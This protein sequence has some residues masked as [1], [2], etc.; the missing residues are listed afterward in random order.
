MGI[1]SDQQYD[2][3]IGSMYDA[4]LDAQRWI[5]VVH[6][7]TRVFDAVGASVYTPFAIKIGL[8]PLWATNADPEYVAAY[9]SKY[10]A[11]DLLAEALWRRV[12]ASTIVYSLD[13]M[14]PRRHDWPVYNELLVPR[15]VH[16]AVGLMVRADD[17]RAGQ[18]SVYSPR[19]SAERLTEAKGVMARLAGHF[20]RAI[21]LHWHLASARQAADATQ[22]TLDMFV[23]GVMWL[24][25]DAT[26]LYTN[27]EMDR[28]LTMADGIALRAGRLVLPD[29]RDQDK[30]LAAIRAAQDGV[31]TALL[32]S[33]PSEQEPYRLTISAL[34]MSASALRLPNASAI[35]FV[36]EAPVLAE[37]SVAAMADA[38]HLTPAE[39]RVLQ[40]LVAGRNI[41][42]AAEE[43]GSRAATVRTQTKSILMKC[44][45]SR[46]ADLI[47]LVTAF[48]QV[49][50]PV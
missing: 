35:A 15:G 19:W 31:Q 9:A 47:R 10:A 21:R 48:P 6:Q 39:T 42:A 28:I 26:V 1:L 11:Q 8:E 45:V 38:Y 5:E 46:Q 36:S 23:T 7:V 12:P 2:Q 4:A 22:I 29:R 41:Q 20:S 17:H 14:L 34:P 43:I 24:S 30:V 16:D 27:A 32:A 33:R 37:A 13:D 25:P 3:I 49:R 50:S 40:M 44:G 18:L